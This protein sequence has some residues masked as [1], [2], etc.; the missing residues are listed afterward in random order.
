MKNI[1]AF[2]VVF[3]LAFNASAFDR[4]LSGVWDY[5]GDKWTIIHVQDDATFVTSDYVEGIGRMTLKFSGKV[6][7][8]GDADQFS[9][10]GKTNSMSI[11]QNGELCQATFNFS[12][13][14]NFFIHGL[15]STLH[16]I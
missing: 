2:S 3:F 5:D 6:T 1:L 9:Y 16:V 4:N 11:R 7:S 8:N 13:F 15:R 14:P 12:S 10:E